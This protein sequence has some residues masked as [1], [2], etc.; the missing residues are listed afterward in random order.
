L[1]LIYLYFSNLHY[2]HSLKHQ[3]KS[4]RKL[5]I[6]IIIVV[7]MYIICFFFSTVGKKTVLRV[8]RRS[9]RHLSVQH[10]AGMAWITLSDKI[11]IKINSCV[12]K[13]TQNVRNN[14]ESPSIQWI[15]DTLQT[16]SPDPATSLR[17]CS[18]R[19]PSN[20]LPEVRRRNTCIYWMVESQTSF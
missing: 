7:I 17:K 3:F 5:G 2:C 12:R 14:N 15:S 1:L 20:R 9:E 13:T 18:W 4:I 16:D 10:L 6:I 8:R 11:N 19:L